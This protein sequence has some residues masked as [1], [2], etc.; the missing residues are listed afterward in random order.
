MNPRCK[1]AMRACQGRAHPRCT[2]HAIE[3]RDLCGP[4]ARE[5]DEG[6]H[7]PRIASPVWDRN[8]QRTMLPS[9]QQMQLVEEIPF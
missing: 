7:V 6:A 1:T 4:C 5:E 9:P 3:G 2:W 8:G